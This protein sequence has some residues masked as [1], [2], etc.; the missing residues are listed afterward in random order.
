MHSMNSRAFAVCILSCIGLVVSKNY[1]I[2]T[3]KYT[4]ACTLN[5]EIL[6]AS[7][8]QYKTSLEWTKGQ[9]INNWE[10]G[11][12]DVLSDPHN[13]ILSNRGI[14]ILNGASVQHNTISYQTT[15]LLP[16]ILKKLINVHLPVKI[17][18]ELFIINNQVKVFV[19]IENV[20][21]ISHLY[22]AN[23]IDISNPTSVSSSH[24]I[25][26]GEIPWYATWTINI[27]KSQILQS[28]DEFDAL[29]FRN[30]CLSI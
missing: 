6:K 21:I 11:E 26:H 24:F 1:L 18:K 29:Y 12:W 25:T 17:Q 14:V 3:K 15:V 8:V 28:V 23:V 19:K 10:M 22:I 7:S 13:P 2:E 16:E 27:L 20:P 9:S 30:A 5:M 4:P